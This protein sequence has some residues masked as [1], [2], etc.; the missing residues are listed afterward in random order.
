M[1]QA[2]TAPEGATGKSLWRRIV[3]FP[4]V[5][6]VLA[7]V[8]VIL[9]FT[10]GM[11][12]AQFLIPPIPGFTLPMK[13]DLVSIPILLLAYEFIIR[14]MGDPKR[15]DFRDREWLRRLGMGLGAGFLVFSVAVGIAALLGVYKITG[16]GDLSGLL[17]ALL[18]SAIFPAISEELVFRGILFR[19]IEEFGGSWLA[20]FLTSAFFGAS[21]LMNPHA[22]TI[23]AVGIAFEAGVMLGAA[24][25]LTRSLWLPMG[26]HAAWNF[27]QGEIY[28][29]PVSGTPVHGLVQ[30]QLTGDPLLTGNGFGLE[31]SLIA[32]VVAT[33]FGLWLL[34]LAIRK[35]ELV[36]PFWVRRRT[37]VAVPA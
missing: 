32:I 31:A 28:D 3:D 33:L 2:V 16:A 20:L 36:Q 4:L 27:T 5:A 22:S 7:L 25:M 12:I 18:A 29:I 10:I 34:W 14:H 24:Y 30:A 11:L 26:L 23:A 21:H 9:C 13:F 19:W 6:M 15:D 17:P 35:G 8:I 1:E 37:A